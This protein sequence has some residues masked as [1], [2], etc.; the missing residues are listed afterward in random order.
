MSG[1][2]QAQSPPPG[3]FIMLTAKADMAS[4]IESIQ[5]GA[6]AYLEKP[7][8]KGELL[9]R[10]Q[11]LLEMRKNLQQYYLKKAKELL[12]DP[13]NSIASVALDCG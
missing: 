13:G 5:R 12:R 8:N 6:D 11:K 9:V 10:I 3:A 2:I 4:K 1:D 7:F